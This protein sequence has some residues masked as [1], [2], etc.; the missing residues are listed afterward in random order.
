ARVS[1]TAAYRHFAG[2]EDLLAG[3]VAVAQRELG[4]ALQ[5]QMG[6][7]ATGTGTAAEVAYAH[8]RGTGRGYV[9]FAV[10]EPGLFDC[11]CT[12]PSPPEPPD[13]SLALLGQALDECLAAGLLGPDDRPGAEDLAWIGVHGLAAQVQLGI[14]PAQGPAFSLL[15]ERTLDFVGRGIGLRKPL[16]A[17]G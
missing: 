10:G 9:L 17:K 2:R 4:A 15:L 5:E 7:A 3:V 8:L 14:H 16:P 11:L 6:L 13:P 12:L 1:A